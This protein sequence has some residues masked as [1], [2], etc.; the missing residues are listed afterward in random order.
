[1]SVRSPIEIP[2]KELI[3]VF[4]LIVQFF[5]IF[6]EPSEKSLQLVKTAPDLIVISF[7][8]ISTPFSFAPDSI[9]VFLDFSLELVTRALLA[10]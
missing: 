8:L 10:I 3:I 1:M 5:P 4:S 7:A 9:T 6:T 2:L